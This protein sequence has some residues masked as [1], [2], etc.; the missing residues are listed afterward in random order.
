LI[1]NAISLFQEILS[2]NWGE[3]SNEFIRNARENKFHAAD[4][5]VEDVVEDEEDKSKEKKDLDQPEES[6]AEEESSADNLEKESPGEIDISRALVYGNL[7]DILNQFRASKSLRDKEVDREL[8]Q[9]YDRLTEEEKKALYVFIKGLTQVT[10]LD[11]A[12]K[13][14]HKPSDKQ[15]SISQTGATSKEKD[16]SKKRAQ[17]L[18]IDASEKEVEDLTDTPITIGQTTTKESIQEMLRIVKE[19][20]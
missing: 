16:R 8:K 12:G 11:I 2:E 14:A 4:N 7:K 3:K 20:A 5:V 18:S 15:L 13:T 9:Y 17:K 19:N 6:N 10:L 1:D